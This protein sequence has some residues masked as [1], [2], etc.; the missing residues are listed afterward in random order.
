MDL[1]SQSRFKVS[2]QRQAL[3]R[4]CECSGKRQEAAGGGGGGVNGS[5]YFHL[6][7]SAQDLYSFLP[8]MKDGL[9]KSLK[10]S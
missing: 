10:G 2:G 8:R 1:T 3:V 9:T 6:P 4:K 5:Q 7:S